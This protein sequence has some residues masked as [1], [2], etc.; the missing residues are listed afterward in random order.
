[1]DAAREETERDARRAAIQEQTAQM[2]KATVVKVTLSCGGICG[3]VTSIYGE[4]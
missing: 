3:V 2:L 1:M 4:I